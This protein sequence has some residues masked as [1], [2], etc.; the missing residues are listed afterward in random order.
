MRV[1]LTVAQFVD[2]V[3]ME[4]GEIVLVEDSIARGRMLGANRAVLLEIL[5]DPPPP[6]VAEIE[7]LAGVVVD[8]AVRYPGERLR[9]GARA[10]EA[11]Q[12]CARV[13]FLP[14]EEV[15][16]KEES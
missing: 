5:P 12:G 4:P 9:I 16:P 8:G 3:P 10:A 7:V 13:R 2:G 1:K 14:P 6:C 11:L 15:Q